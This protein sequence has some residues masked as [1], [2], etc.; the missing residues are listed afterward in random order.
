VVRKLTL[1]EGESYELAHEVMVD[2]VWQW[3][4]EEEARFK[5][6]RDMLR[7]NLNNYRNLGLLMPLDRLEIVNLYREEMSLSREELEL[8]FRSALAAGYEA[9]YW[10]DRADQAGLLEQLEDEWLDKLEDEATAAEAI[11]ALGGIA[12]PRLVEQL[13]QIVEADFAEGAVCDV[14]H[15]TTPSQR[16]AV[17]ALSKMTCP[18]ASAALGRWTPEGMIL[19]PAGPFI[20]G[21]TEQSDEGPVH[22]VWLDV[23]WIERYPVTNVQWAAFMEAGGYQRRELW[24]EAG[25]EWKEGESLKPLEW[26]KHGR[27]LDHPV[28]GIC[29]YEALT[30]ARWVGKAL[31]SEAQWEKAAR[32]TDRRRYPWGDEFDQGRCNAGESGIGDTTPVGRYSPA[33]ESLY[34]VADMAG[35]VYEWCC[36]LYRPYPYNAAD[37][38][39]I[40]EGTGGRVQRGGSFLDNDSCARAARRGRNLPDFRDIDGGCRVGWCAAF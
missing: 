40:L 30:Y 12:T 1:A 7:Q 15:L 8:L 16:R 39:E 3:V 11:V 31:L 22:E 14:L 27:K 10:R 13:G 25:W 37:G 18:E 21:S 19:I 20:M 33:G 23:F 32:G 5:H 6:A 24:T 38:R 36:S 2:K 26:D 28:Q 34:G 17:A 4:T 9:A 29:W 35:N